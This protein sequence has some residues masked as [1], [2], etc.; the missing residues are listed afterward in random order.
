MART[1]RLKA[2]ALVLVPVGAIAK[3][4]GHHLPMK[5]DWLVARELPHRI[6]QRLGD[7]LVQ[8]QTGSTFTRRR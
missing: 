3:E 5:T 2:R 7:E 1:T 4:H 8:I 6:P